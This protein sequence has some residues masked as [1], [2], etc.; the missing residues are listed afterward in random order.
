VILNIEK[1]QVYNGRANE[2]Q[3][4]V[5]NSSRIIQDLTTVKNKLQSL[6]SDATTDGYSQ[7]DLDIISMRLADMKTALTK[8]INSI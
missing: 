7:E 3:S 1:A 4:M 2:L 8:L 5:K 6:L